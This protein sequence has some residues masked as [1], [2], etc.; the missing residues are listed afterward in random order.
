MRCQK[1]QN[2]SKK[3][4]VKRRRWEDDV[5]RRQDVRHWRKK[6]KETQVS[7]RIPCSWIGRNN[8]I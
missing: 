6:V 4:K 3:K 8:I 7:G 2:F 1:A 5:K